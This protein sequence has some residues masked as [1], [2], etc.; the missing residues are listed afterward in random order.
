MLSLVM[1]G[2]H[3]L[4]LKDSSLDGY[5]MCSLTLVASPKVS[6]L[7]GFIDWPEDEGVV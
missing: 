7:A 6:S 4:P 5:A 3:E 1:A 2:T